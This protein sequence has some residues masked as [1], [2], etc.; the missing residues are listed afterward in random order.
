MQSGPFFFLNVNWLLCSIRWINWNQK[1]KLKTEYVGQENIFSC[2]QYSKCI[3]ISNCQ[4]QRNSVYSFSFWFQFIQRLE[5]YSAFYR[6]ILP[7]KPG[8]KPNFL[9]ILYGQD[10]KFKPFWPWR[11]Y[12]RKRCKIF[13]VQKLFFSSFKN[14]FQCQKDPNL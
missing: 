1:L 4:Q 13:M 6:T 5:H 14:V 11:V 3:K 9:G 2:P 7:S 12:A 8:P 10:L